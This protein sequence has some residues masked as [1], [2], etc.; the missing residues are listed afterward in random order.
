MCTDIHMHVLLSQALSLI[1]L[2]LSCSCAAGVCNAIVCADSL[3][4]LFWQQLV[5]GCHMHH[6]VPEILSREAAYA[7]DPPV[8]KVCQMLRLLA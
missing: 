3:L 8:H 7:T 2:Q 1:P 6:P 5:D 4:R